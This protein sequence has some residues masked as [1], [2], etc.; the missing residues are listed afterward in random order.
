MNLAYTS[1]EFGDDRQTRLLIDGLESLHSTQTN[2]VE[3]AEE[4]AA[5]R[6]FQPGKTGSTSRCVALYSHDTQGLG[7]LRRNVNIASIL[8]SLGKD[9]TLLVI[10]GSREVGKLELPEGAD[11]LVL[12]SI[13]KDQNS[14]YQSKHLKVSL[15]KI[16]ALRQAVIQEAIGLFAPDILIVDKTPWGFEREL[17]PSLRMLT[18]KGHCQ[19]VLGLRDV[20]DDPKVAA[21][22][23]K[24]A[25][26]D[27]AVANFYQ[28]VWIYGD[29]KIHRLDEMCHF[30]DTTKAKVHYT[31][32]I[33]P[34]EI[35][36][37]DAPQS[38]SLLNGRHFS[39]RKPYVLCLVG[40]GQDGYKLAHHFSESQFGQGRSGVIV[41]GPYMPKKDK[42]SLAI[43]ARNRQDLTI[44]DFVSDILPLVKGA[45]KIVS[46]GGYNT[47]SEIV[48]LNKPA[49]I[50]PRT[51]PRKEQLIRAEALAQVGIIDSALLEDLNPDYL[52]AWLAEPLEIRASSQHYFN[53]N[54]VSTIKSLA[55]SLMP[56]A[57][58]AESDNT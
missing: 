46:M 48:T 37:R 16:M 22:E 51:Q 4:G 24:T 35:A 5:D 41:T 10:C 31:G 49:L 43:M 42:Q 52:T 18:Q 23:W 44:Y 6:E 58:S 20:L 45:D 36:S 13:H 28:Q 54:G 56:S 39:H 9:I 17:E 14:N 11:T 29:P 53:V 15:Q 40:G 1:W 12:P 7:H 33:N 38:D 55:S 57:T 21:M 47:V 26:N 34:W 25:D 30:K 32:Y 8:A 19:C 50:V 3:A 27:R 2:R